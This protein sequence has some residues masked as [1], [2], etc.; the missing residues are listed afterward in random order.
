MDEASKWRWIDI[1]LAI[2][3][4]VVVAYGVLVLNWSVF[5]VIALFWFENVVIGVLNVAKMLIVGVRMGAVGIIG[6]VAL[7]SFFVVHYGMF[8]V[9]HGALLAQLFGRAELGGSL[10]GL[11]E[12]A[13]R[14]LDY[15]LTDRDAWFAVL[16][17]TLLQVAVFFRWWGTSRSDP[18][19]VPGLMLAPYG[20]VIILH[21]TLIVGGI[22]AAL[23]Q[24][25]VLGALMLVA[26][27]LVFDVVAAGWVVKGQLMPAIARSDPRSENAT[28]P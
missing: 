11:F 20:R 26:L 22:L 3:A 21:V 17:I 19:P 16:G 5:V 9:G 27:K 24:A 8:T 25:P 4:A 15:L 2:A 18:L 1:T 7:G 28:R 10:N 13:A 12:P 14:M 23:L 6:A